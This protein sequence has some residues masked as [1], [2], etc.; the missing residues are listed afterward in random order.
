M[1]F[2]LFTHSYRCGKHTWMTYF[3]VSYLFLDFVFTFL[4]LSSWIL[5]CSFACPVYCSMLKKRNSKKLKIIEDRREG[6]DCKTLLNWTNES[7][8]ESD[9]WRW[10]SIY[11]TQQILFYYI[12]IHWLMLLLCLLLF[13]LT[14]HISALDWISWRIIIVFSH[15]CPCLFDFATLFSAIYSFILF[16]CYWFSWI[17]SNSRQ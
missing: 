4:M 8:E 16:C 13:Q 10:Q 14:P 12:R 3:F 1:Y 6:M 9:T 11:K 2:H 17:Q 7:T 5:C 15:F